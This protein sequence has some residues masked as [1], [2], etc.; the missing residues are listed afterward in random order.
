MAA[1]PQD[2][3]ERL[4]LYLAEESSGV[5]TLAVV[6]GRIVSASFDGGEALLGDLA[7]RRLVR[8]TAQEALERERVIDSLI[9]KMA[10]S[11]RRPSP[12]V[13]ERNC[14]TARPRA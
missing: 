7:F 10:D 8:Q 4:K 13:D 6:R 11:S 5:V 14:L 2:I 1:I 12:L 3:W 9:A